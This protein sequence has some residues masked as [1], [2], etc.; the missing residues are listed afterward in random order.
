MLKTLIII[1]IF[2]FIANYIIKNLRNLRTGEPNENNTNYWMFTYDFKETKKSSIFDRASTE[3]LEKR[4]TKNKLIILLY[5]TVVILFIYS[6]LFFT[7][8]LLFILEKN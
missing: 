7:Q 2:Y 3:I 4:K 5:L 8:I 1:S 6:N